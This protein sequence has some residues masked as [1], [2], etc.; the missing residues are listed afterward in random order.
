MAPG[1][2]YCAA[3]DIFDPVPNWHYLLNMPTIDYTCPECG[4]RFK[5]VV[6]RG[7]PIEALPCP[8]CHGAAA[9]PGKSPKALFDGIAGFSD[10][11]KDTN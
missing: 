10:L 7:D 9:S 6:M 11:A 3:F 8:Q 1:R 5:R 2:P 4:H